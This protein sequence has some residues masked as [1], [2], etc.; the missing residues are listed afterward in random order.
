MVD[1]RLM[2]ELARDRFNAVSTMP[3]PSRSR[4]IDVD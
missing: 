2:S 1:D 4:V 3:L